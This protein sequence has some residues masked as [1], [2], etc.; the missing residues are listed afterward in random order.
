MTD[1]TELAVKGQGTPLWS[2]GIQRVY[3]GD[4]V[5]AGGTKRVKTGKLGESAYVMEK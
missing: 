5:G 4:I 2:T 3:R 1:K